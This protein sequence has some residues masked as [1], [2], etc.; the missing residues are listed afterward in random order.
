V[1]ELIRAENIIDDWKVPVS[2]FN[3]RNGLRYRLRKAHG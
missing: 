2:G 1:R 3:L